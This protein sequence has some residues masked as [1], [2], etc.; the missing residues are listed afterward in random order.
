[1][2]PALVMARSIAALTSRTGIPGLQAWTAAARAC[3]AASTMRPLPVP[4]TFTVVAVSTTHP[5]M[6]TPMSSLARS[7]GSYVRSSSGV[8]QS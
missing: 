1:M 7:P 5:S 8:G 3:R 2:K 4:P 6:C